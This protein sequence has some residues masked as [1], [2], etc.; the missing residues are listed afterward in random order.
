MR[1]ADT[2]SVDVSFKLRPRPPLFVERI[3]IL[4]NVRTLDMVEY[5]QPT[6]FSCRKSSWIALRKH[7]EKR[8][9]P[10]SSA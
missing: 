5:P 9:P 7:D 6:P 10:P 4:G 2:R 8:L 3:D 1:H